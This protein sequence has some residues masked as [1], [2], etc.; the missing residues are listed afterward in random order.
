MMFDWSLITSYNFLMMLHSFKSFFEAL[1]N[2]Y[3]YSSI[4]HNSGEYTSRIVSNSSSCNVWQSLCAINLLT[5]F[6]GFLRIRLDRLSGNL[7]LTSLGSYNKIN[8]VI[9]LKLHVLF[10]ETNGW[11]GRSK[12]W[13]ISPQLQQ[14]RV[15]G[16]S[17][18]THFSKSLEF[19]ALIR[20]L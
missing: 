1:N 13:D 12:L 17:D 9:P 15:N 5:K 8:I 20:L 14:I 3:K 10:I 4:S 11:K 2:I 7:V 18:C 6:W 16:W 19:L